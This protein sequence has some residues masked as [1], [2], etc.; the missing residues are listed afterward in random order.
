MGRPFGLN[1]LNR[2]GALLNR[3]QGEIL[4]VHAKD[5]GQKSQKGA[6]RPTLGRPA[7]FCGGF[8]PSFARRFLKAV[9]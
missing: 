9:A 7:G 2:P 4:D 5:G 3:H 1:C 6:G 8:A